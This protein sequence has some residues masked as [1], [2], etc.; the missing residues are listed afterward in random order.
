MR[1]L[2]KL[3][4]WVGAIS[5]GLTVAVLLLRYTF[6]SLTGLLLPM[7]LGIFVSFGIAMLSLRKLPQIKN[8][9]FSPSGFINV[10][11]TLLAVPNWQKVLLA[12]TVVFW[13][14]RIVAFENLGPEPEAEEF[15][16]AMTGH[17]LMFHLLGAVLS[18]RMLTLT[19][20][21]ENTAT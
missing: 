10:W 15:F 9:R 16:L 7:F 2:L 18:S 1:R 5:Y 8:D 11:G 4:V 20:Q 3:S 12:A 19:E 14:T 17:I 13:M 6:P 21:L